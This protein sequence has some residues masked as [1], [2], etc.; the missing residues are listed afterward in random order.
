MNINL[1]HFN[2]QQQLDKISTQD[3]LDLNPAEIDHYIEKALYA[4]LREQV[5]FRKGRGV[6]FDETQ[7]QKLS[8]LVVRSPLDQVA[9]PP[10]AT[11]GRI[12]EFRESSLTYDLYHILRATATITDGTCTKTANVS[13]V[14]HDD[15]SEMLDDSLHAP[16]LAWNRVLA[17]V[18]KSSG[19]VAD[20]AI[21]VYTDGTFSVT[22]LMLDYIKHPVI[23]AVD[24]YADIDGNPKVITQL[25]LPDEVHYEIIDKTVE[26]I[27]I[28]FNDPSVQLYSYN[29]KNNQ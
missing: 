8:T 23:P 26:L 12:Y 16:S 22:D 19:G 28:A 29:F 24:T 2:I 21:Y 13:F 10:D 27:S 17:V 6:E 20:K 1:V 25:D 15:L 5:D 3:K 9:I 14:E 18:G 7:I 11:S 4:W